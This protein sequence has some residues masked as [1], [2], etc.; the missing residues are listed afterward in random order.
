MALDLSDV[1][2]DP[3]IAESFTIERS[4][5]GFVRGGWSNAVDRIPAFG[6]VSVVNENE[7]DMLP[8]ADRILGARVFYSTQEM[9][10]TSVQRSGLSDVLIYNDE[11]YRV[12]NVAPYGNRGY[13]R[14]YAARMVGD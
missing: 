5:G 12:F 10:V 13:F 8:E 14:A 9:Y 1:V 7:L 6:V 3:D 2:S 11:K 4:S